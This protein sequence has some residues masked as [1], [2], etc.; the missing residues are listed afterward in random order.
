MH[1]F[2]RIQYVMGRITESDVLSMVP[3]Y[4]TAEQANSIIGGVISWPIMYQK[5]GL[6]EKP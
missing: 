1:E 2:I 4:I 3:K 6:L 5:N